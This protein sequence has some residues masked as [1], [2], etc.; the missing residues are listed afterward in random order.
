MRMIL[1]MKL[2]KFRPREAE[3][4]ANGSLR[5]NSLAI[6]NAMA[7]CTQ[8]PNLN[9]L[10]RIFSGGVGVFHVKGWGPKSSVCPSK[11]GKPNFFGGISRDFA[12]ISR[13]CPKS[14]RKKHLCFNFCSLSYNRAGPKGV[15]T[16][17]VSMKRSNFPRL[18]LF[19]TV[20][21]K[22]NFQKIVLIMDALLQKPFLVLDDI[23]S[24]RK[25][26][27]RE[28]YRGIIFWGI[29]RNCRNRLREI[30]LGEFFSGWLRFVACFPES[31]CEMAICPLR[32]NILEEF[33]SGWIERNLRN[34]C[35]K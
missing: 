14:L 35:V 28:N 13:R 16:N 20:V 17:G 8:N 11:P 2:R 7:W 12:G 3:I 18:R 21:S 6:A 25:H 5:Q 27:A 31:I 15:S 1:R 24:F 10:V 9:F 34:H 4:L 29:A 22:R 19:Y 32:Q 26:C 33:F 23:P 30:T